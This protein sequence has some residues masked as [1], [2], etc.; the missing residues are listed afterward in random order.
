[1]PIALPVI[2]YRRR[3]DDPVL[4]G[5]VELQANTLAITRAGRAGY[6]ARLRPRPWDLRRI[7]GWGRK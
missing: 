4:G 3:M 7:T 2:D 6:A 5:T 1:M